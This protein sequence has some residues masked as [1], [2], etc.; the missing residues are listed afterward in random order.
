MNEIAEA[1]AG[2]FYIATTEGDQPHVR[3]FDN[4]V[5][6]EDKLY[7]GTNN[8][9]KVYEQIKKNPKVEIFA[10]EHGT[11]RF[12]ADAFPVEDASLNETIFDLLAKNFDDTSV[13]IELKNIK[14][15][16]L[17]IMGDKIELN[18]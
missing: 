12:T 11:I 17:S 18:F 8:T 10:M 3:P 6:Y 15:S 2:N 5:V 9:K 13:A 1:L 14:G 16:F 7:I 4:A